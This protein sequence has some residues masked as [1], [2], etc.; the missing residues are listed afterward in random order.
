[1][2][3][4][5]QEKM[6]QN[7]VLKM[8]VLSESLA[9]GQENLSHSFS[10]IVRINNHCFA[11]NQHYTGTE[12]YKFEQTLAF[13]FGLKKCQITTIRSNYPPPLFQKFRINKGEGGVIRLVEK[14]NKKSKKWPKMEGII[15]RIVVL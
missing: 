11:I 3:Y 9:D 6:L 8:K 5:L 12:E 14:V 10:W 15:E 4:S 7:G 13:T 2:L 1:M